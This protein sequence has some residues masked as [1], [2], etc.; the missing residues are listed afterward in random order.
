MATSLLKLGTGGGS[1]SGGNNIPFKYFT[2]QLTPAAG[3]SVILNSQLP[4]DFQAPVAAFTISGASNTATQLSYSGTNLTLY[5]AIADVTSTWTILYKSLDGS[6]EGGT[7]IISSNTWQTYIAPTTSTYTVTSEDGYRYTN[8]ELFISKMFTNGGDL[9][10]KTRITLG[11][12]TT[13]DDY[14]KVRYIGSAAAASAVNGNLDTSVQIIV[15]EEGSIVADVRSDIKHI[16]VNALFQS[17]RQSDILHSGVPVDWTSS[18]SANAGYSK[19]PDCTFIQWGV[20]TVAANAFTVTATF[21]AAFNDTNYRLTVTP[22]DGGTFYNVS[23]KTIGGFTIN[24]SPSEVA[25]IYEWIA[26]GR[27][28]E[29]DSENSIMINATSTPVIAVKWTGL[30]TIPSSIKTSNRITEDMVIV[31]TVLSNPSAQTSSWNVQLLSGSA[32]ITS[33][34]ISGM[35]DIEIYLQQSITVE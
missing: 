19:M 21:S 26:I 22:R 31:D 28:K 2:L 17:R 18:A 35:T 33:G 29:P 25:S 13:V 15:T 27:W 34:T 10:P 23:A 20:A 12:L 16:Y 11:Q 5:A 4:S 8:G 9:F 24:R 7:N 6:I 30:D 14:P 3:V 1:G 32:Q